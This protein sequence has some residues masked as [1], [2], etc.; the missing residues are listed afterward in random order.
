MRCSVVHLHPSRRIAPGIYHERRMLR[1][2]VVA[3][4]LS[5]CSAAEEVLFGLK[6]VWLFELPKQGGTTA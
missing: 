3:P 1:L 4:E 2:R 6:C 5:L